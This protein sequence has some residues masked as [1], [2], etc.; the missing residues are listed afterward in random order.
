MDVEEFPPDMRP[1]G[2]VAD[3][4]GLVEVVEAGIAVGLQR[5][6]EGFQVLPRMLALAIRGLLEEHGWRLRAAGWS[7]IPDIRPQPSGL[8]L[9]FS[10]R[11][12]RYRHVVGMQLGGRHDI[13]TQSL[14]QR[15][16]QGGTAADP[17]GQRGAFN[18]DTVAGVDLGLPVQGQRIA[19]LG[20]QH[21]AQQTRCGQPPRNRSRW[22]VGLDHPLARITGALRP[23]MPDHLPVRRHIV[24]HFGDV[25]ADRP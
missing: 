19:V 12:H 10:R 2:G 4:S 15:G 18:L 8:G 22:G 11:Q 1:A 17:V 16:E 6:S 3:P 20:D 13:R 21:M 14:D 25:F 7:I 23:D 9:A 5:A 24:E